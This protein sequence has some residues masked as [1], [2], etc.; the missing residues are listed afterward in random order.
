MIKIIPSHIAVI[1]DGN[2]RWAKFNKLPK[3]DGYE[4]GIKTLKSLSESVV[5]FGEDNLKELYVITKVGYNHNANTT[6]KIYK[7]TGQRIA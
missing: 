1:M 5:G 2:A 3:K 6:G 4:K 7:F